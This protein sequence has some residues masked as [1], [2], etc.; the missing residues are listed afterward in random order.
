MQLIELSKNKKENIL[1]MAEEIMRFPCE[2][3][4]KTV[5]QAIVKVVPTE[6]IIKTK[7]YKVV[8]QRTDKTVILLIYTM[9]DNVPHA[10]AV[11]GEKFFYWEGGK[12]EELEDEL[13][14]ILYR[15]G[16]KLNLWN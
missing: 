13:N 8:I 11:L 3:L 4:I 10:T 12:L 2:L 7:N 6:L 16:R 1:I 14:S 5:P 15:A 9:F